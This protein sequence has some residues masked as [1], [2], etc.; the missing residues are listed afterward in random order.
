M[1]GRG[2]AYTNTTRIL[3][4]RTAQL[5]QA[6]HAVIWASHF[7]P[8]RQLSV[9][10]STK[11]YDVPSELMLSRGADLIKAARDLNVEYIL[12]GH[13][14][15]AGLTEIGSI[16]PNNNIYVI[17]TGSA[18]AT[19]QHF[20]GTEEN[21]FLDISLSVDSGRV[22]IVRIKKIAYN[23]KK[24]CFPEQGSILHFPLRGFA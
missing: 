15:L 9:Q 22:E 23:P 20:C 6:G 10:D 17:T 21:S 4:E 12:C 1:W 5:R 3:K 7:P 19:P 13:V 14:H 8:A 18:S 11:I 24:N 2:K 16:L